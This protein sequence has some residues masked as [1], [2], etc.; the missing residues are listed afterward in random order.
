MTLRYLVD[1]D[2]VIH[3]LNG[4]Q[5]II[6]RLDAAQQEGVG[7]SMI[8]L[9]ELYEGVYYSRDPEGNAAALQDFLAG[10][11]ALG[12]DDQTCRLFG[13]ERGRLRKGGKSIADFDLIIGTTALQHDLTLFTNNSRHFSRIE[14]LR[15]ESIK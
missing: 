3:Y 14:G 9:A 13:Q 1:T 4:H 7:I 10:I 6:D 8:S 5:R 2:W 11:T 15:L 12:I